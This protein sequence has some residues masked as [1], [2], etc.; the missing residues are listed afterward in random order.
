MRK[1]RR[2]EGRK[3]S[4]EGRREK[5]TH[6]V[7][8][9]RCP[10]TRLHRQAQVSLVV[11][12]ED[13]VPVDEATS[14]SPGKEVRR[15]KEGAPTLE[16][17]RQ[18]AARRA[19]RPSARSHTRNRPTALPPLLLHLRRHHRLNFRQRLLLLL[20]QHPLSLRHLFPLLLDV[21][22]MN[23]AYTLST[24]AGLDIVIALSLAAE[25]GLAAVVAGTEGDTVADLDGVLEVD[26]GD[27]IDEG[28]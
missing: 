19:P 1:E 13:E 11:T 4:A 2:N 9:L 23:A 6:L 22:A 27:I 8:T 12:L 17:L 5:R 10:Q 18:K 16:V 25:E 14:A 3:E 7:V 26:V 20:R 24:D 15:R 21:R 28:A